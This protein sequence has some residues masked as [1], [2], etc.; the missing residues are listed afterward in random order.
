[1]KKASGSA[2]MTREVLAHIGRFVTVSFLCVILERSEE[3]RSLFFGLFFV[4]FR[5]AAAKNPGVLIGLVVT[6]APSDGLLKIEDARRVL[7]Y[8]RAQ[9]HRIDAAQVG[10]DFEGA[11]DV[12][13]FV[14]F[15]AVGVG[16]E[17]GGVG[18]YHHAV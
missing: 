14:A 17:I 10:E 4:S 15:A 7:H 8:L 9:D 13:G 2:K 5:A 12:G 1:M 18:F 11:G 3:S 16:G 6:P